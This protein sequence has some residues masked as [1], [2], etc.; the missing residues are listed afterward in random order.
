MQFDNHGLLFSDGLQN[1]KLIFGN[2]GCVFLTFGTRAKKTLGT[3]RLDYLTNFR[4]H[5]YLSSLIVHQCAG[6]HLED[7]SDHQSGCWCST[8]RGA[9]G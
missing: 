9:Q 3:Q 2:T 5:A 7:A 6:D 4:I 8:E 1:W